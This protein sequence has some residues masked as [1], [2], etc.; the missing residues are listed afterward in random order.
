MEARNG[1]VTPLYKFNA[2]I[3]FRWS[4]ITRL[5]PSLIQQRSSSLYLSCCSFYWTRI[6]AGVFFPFNSRLLN[7]ILCHETH[8]S[9]YEKD[10]LLKALQVK[11][12]QPRNMNQ[13]AAND[14][15]IIKRKFPFVRIGVAD[16][17][18][19]IQFS[20]KNLRWYV[21]SLSYDHL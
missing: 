5:L 13:V 7:T 18:S 17:T 8:D 3:G 11:R 12:K 1:W 14:F 4:G 15:K 2:Q 16:E 20:S 21:W 9:T 6:G 10:V 19:G